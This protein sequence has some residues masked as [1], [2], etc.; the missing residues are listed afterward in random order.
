MKRKRKRKHRKDRWRT[1]DKI[2][3]K[4]QRQYR[5]R[6]AYCAIAVRARSGRV[7]SLAGAHESGEAKK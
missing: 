1:V 5:K 2:R 7:C 3:A 4:W 6:L